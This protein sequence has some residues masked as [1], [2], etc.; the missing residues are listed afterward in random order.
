MVGCVEE[1]GEEKNEAAIPA[2]EVNKIV[3]ADVISE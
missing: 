1:E 3:M 2:R